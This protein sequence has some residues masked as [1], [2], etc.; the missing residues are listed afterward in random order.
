MLF[1]MGTSPIRRG[2]N[3]SGSVSAGFVPAFLCLM[4]GVC[5]GVDSRGDLLTVTS[6]DLSH[7]AGT[8]HEIARLPMWF[9]RHCV[10]SKA[11]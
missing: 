3:R 1:L 6:M 9:Q 10:D 2:A 8:W 7:Y 5:A 4:L 11:I